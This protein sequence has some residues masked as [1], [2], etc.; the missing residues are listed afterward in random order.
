MQ[1]DLETPE[2]CEDLDIGELTWNDKV[3][4]SPPDSSEAVLI[5][6][7]ARNR[8]SQN[9]GQGALWDTACSVAQLWISIGRSFV[10]AAGSGR[11]AGR[12]WRRW[13]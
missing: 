9:R 13:W 2:E 4:Q 11:A 3:A 5:G 8:Q 1:G 6:A 10:Q 12:G 7:G